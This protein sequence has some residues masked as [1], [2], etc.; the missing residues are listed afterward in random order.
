MPSVY[1]RPRSTVER[2]DLCNKAHQVATH[3]AVV[4]PLLYW[5]IKMALSSSDFTSN[6]I[7]Y[8][9]DNG[10]IKSNVAESEDIEPQAGR[11]SAR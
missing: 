2:A 10:L 7:K 9:F 4:D 5:S 3:D 6:I 11:S 1:P 8:L